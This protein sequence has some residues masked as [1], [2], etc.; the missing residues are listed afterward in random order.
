M[1]KFQQNGLLDNVN[2]SFGELSSK[3]IVQPVLCH[4]LPLI[5]GIVSIELE[6]SAQ[7]VD[8]YNAANSKEI[9]EMNMKMMK[10]TR[11]LYARLT[12]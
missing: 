5:N 7:L 4:I 8:I 10:E 2:L 1:Q 3:N 12:I 11:I 6:E 9:C